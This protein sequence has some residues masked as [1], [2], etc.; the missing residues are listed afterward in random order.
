MQR[1]LQLFLPPSVSTSWMRLVLC[2]RRRLDGIVSVLLIKYCAHK[3]RC[4]V[5][6]KILDVVSKTMF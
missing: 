6:E 3:S 2:H 4:S 1:C 5:E